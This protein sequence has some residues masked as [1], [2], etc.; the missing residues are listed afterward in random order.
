MKLFVKIVNDLQLFLQKAPP[1]KFDK[2]LNT[3]LS[4]NHKDKQTKQRNKH[5]SKV[6]RWFP[7]TNSH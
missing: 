5:W 4:V 1:W 2:V 3:P 7:T 6:G